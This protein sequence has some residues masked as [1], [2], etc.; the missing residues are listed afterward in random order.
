MVLEKMAKPL[1]QLIINEELNHNQ[2]GFRPK[3]DCGSAKAMIFYKS[4]RIKD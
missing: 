4:K 3:S 1:I 2:F